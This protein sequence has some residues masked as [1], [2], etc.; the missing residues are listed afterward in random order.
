[1]SPAHTILVKNTLDK[2]PAL[3]NPEARTQLGQR[4]PNTIVENLGVSLPDNQ[5]CEVMLPRKEYRVLGRVGYCSILNSPST[6]PYP[7]LILEEVKLFLPLLEVLVSYN[8]LLTL[9]DPQP[10]GIGVLEIVTGDT[11]RP[12][13]AQ[14]NLA[15]L[16]YKIGDGKKAIHRAEVF[17]L[18]ILAQPSSGISGE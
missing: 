1:M 14:K 15:K 18:N 10:F 4:L 16:H 13:L 2:A 8:H 5:L 6:S 9:E 3:D 7:M 12:N 17:I 11:V